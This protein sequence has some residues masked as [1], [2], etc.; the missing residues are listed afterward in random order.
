MDHAQKRNTILLSAKGADD[1][2]VLIVISFELSRYRAQIGYLSLLDVFRVPLIR[3]VKNI[4]RIA[5]GEGCSE[6]LIYAAP[7]NHFVI[8][9]IAW[10]LRGEF[11]E[12]RFE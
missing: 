10:I 6:L 1:P 9:L 8:D 4:R 11:V 5:A 2:D 3:K 12:Y 7:G